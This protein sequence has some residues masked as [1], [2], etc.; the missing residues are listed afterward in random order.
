M[1]NVVYYILSAQKKIF[2]MAFLAVFSSFYTEVWGETWTCG[3]TTIS[4]SGS[5]YVVS[6]IADTNGAMGDLAATPTSDWGEYK[7]KNSSSYT[8]IIFEEGVT[9]IG[10][11]TFDGFTYVTS[12]T[13]PTSIV[14]SG[15]K[16]FNGC[17]K[18]SKLYYA[19]TPSEW[20][21]IDFYNQY[22]HPFCALSIGTGKLHMYGKRTAKS[23]SILVLSPTITEIKPYAFYKAN[24]AELSIPGTIETI[25]DY[26]FYCKITGNVAINRKNKPTTGTSSL[27]FDNS[28]T[29]YLYIPAGAS[30]YSSNPWYD[31]S[32]TNGAKYIGRSGDH[33]AC[34][35]TESGTK[36]CK[37]SGS[38]G[39]NMT[40]TLSED[41]TLTFTGHGA[42]T[43][44]EIASDGSSATVVPWCRLRRLI[45]KVVVQGDKT[46]DITGFGNNTIRYMFGLNEVD[47]KQTTIPT[48]YIVF[49]D[50]F[51]SR[52]N[53]TLKIKPASLTNASA[54][55]LGS[56]PW[57]DAKLDIQL[58]DD[59]V[60]D[61]AS[62]DNS[63]ILTNC[64][65]YVEKPVNVQ[66]TRSTLGSEMYNTFCSP[67]SMTAE[68]VTAMFGAETELVEFDGTEIIDGVLNLKFKD[69]SSIT[70]GKPYLIW[71]ESPVSNP[72]FTDVNPASIATGGQTVEGGYADFIGTL[73]PVDASDYA[74]NKN[75]IFL[76]ADNKLT[77]AT[78]GTL[79]GMRAYFLLKEG[80]PASVMAKR[81][82]LQIGNGENTTTDLGQVPSDKIQCTKVLRNG[83][84]YILRGEKAYNLQGIEIDRPNKL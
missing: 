67:V 80:T 68:E 2:V 49:N 22:A 79:K 72:T 32:G 77:Y 35:V 47:V 83:Q 44:Y 39:A 28:K 43:N 37:T 81:P 8:S 10:A 54:S 74:K 29:T 61:Q 45:Y 48:A 19:G 40:W 7:Y 33:T 21:S 17:S 58:S 78:G 23:D 14:S 30:S 24:I 5:S 36:K 3:N 70:A 26:A 16:A 50:L 73:A 46:G 66:L 38:C 64:S 52:D 6:P 34:T 69:A 53:I 55:R 65:T 75:F 57:N 62:G 12:V 18:L 56:A 60:I 25:G 31:A 11:H 71:P 9:H 76:L 84:I 4:I 15:D 41:G 51:N 42:M 1:K 13:I 20:A 82:V 63:T 59:L 27:T